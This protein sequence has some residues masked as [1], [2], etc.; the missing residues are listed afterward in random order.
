MNG[1]ELSSSNFMLFAAKHYDNPSCISI[2]EF[3]DD[4]KRI[5]YIKRLLKRYKKTGKIGERL[6]LNHIILLHNVFNE[7]VVPILFYKIEQEH[8]SQ[9]KTF[10][11]FLQYLPDKYEIHNDVIET[12]IPLDNTIINKLRNI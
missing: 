10:L 11:V 4:L 6:L 3:H 7:A 5:K 8:W 2:K 12:E 1:V 9:L